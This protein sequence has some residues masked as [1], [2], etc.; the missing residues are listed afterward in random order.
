MSQFLT[1]IWLKWKLLRNSL[2]SRKAVVNQV[3]SV[4]GVLVTLLIAL[5]VAIG[6][7]FAAYFLTKPGAMSE[8]FRRGASREGFGSETAELVLFSIFSFLYLMWATVPLSIGSSK[9]FDAGRML[10]YPIS[11]SRLFAI[12][13]VSEVTTLASMFGIP[14]ILATSIGAGLG[15]GH[16]LPAL[17]AGV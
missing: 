2:R 11:L 9:Q 5:T 17:V 1:L 6:L 10:I 15:T 13:F 7:G 3:A 16:L 8:A 4:L 12:D 14:A